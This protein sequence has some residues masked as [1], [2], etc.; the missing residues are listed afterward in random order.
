MNEMLRKFLRLESASGILLIVAALTMFLIEV[1]L[2]A[3]TIRVR[4]EVLFHEVDEQR[5]EH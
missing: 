4:D 5:C 1:H 3:R 2:A